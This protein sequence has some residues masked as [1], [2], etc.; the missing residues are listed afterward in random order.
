MM[1]MMMMMM[2]VLSYHATA[3]VEQLDSFKVRTSLCLRQWTSYDMIT[4]RP[5]VRLSVCLSVCL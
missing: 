5:S 3:P 1:M 4:V 2:Q